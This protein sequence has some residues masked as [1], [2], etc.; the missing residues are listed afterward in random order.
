MLPNLIFLNNNGAFLFYVCT[1][2]SE[3][4]RDEVK[5]FHMKY[6]SLHMHKKH[7]YPYRLGTN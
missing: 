3:N 6:P 2:S 7:T 1:F 4:E 5:V